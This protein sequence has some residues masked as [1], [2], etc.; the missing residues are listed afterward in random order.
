[1]YPGNLFALIATLS[2]V[3]YTP[4]VSYLDWKYRDIKTHSIWIPL[5][6]INLPTLIAGYCLG[7]YP[8]IL[9]VPSLIG[10]VAWFALMRLNILP[11][12]DFVFLSLISLFM[13]INPIDG[14]PF[15]RAF[16]IY[17]VV[18]GA[19]T[20]WY[21]FLDNLLIKHKWSLDIESPGIP[22]LIP[23][24]CALITAVVMG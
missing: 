11:G 22:Y 24:S 3:A 7:A 23:I 14:E 8:L 20:F 15:T 10:M 19:A 12:G 18:F 5:I 4:I 9:V 13:V 16:A 1:M 6:A 17:L 21:V 2:F